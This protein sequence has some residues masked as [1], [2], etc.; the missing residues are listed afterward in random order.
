MRWLIHKKKSEMGPLLMR[1]ILWGFLFFVAVGAVAACGGG[2]SKGSSAGA[3]VGVT[4]EQAAAGAAD[5]VGGA[6]KSLLG[7]VG[8]SVGNSSAAETILN[9]LGIPPDSDPTANL[10]AQLGEAIAL[11]LENGQRT[12]DAVTFDPDE[13]QLCSDPLLGQVT[14]LVGVGQPCIDFYSHITVVLTPGGNA[15]EGTL[16]IKY[17]NFVLATID[18]SSG[19]VSLQL[20]LA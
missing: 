14:L 2:G 19:S 18:Y 17:D 11:I 1:S 20:D 3:P 15:E 12:G 9:A 4:P 10:E 6:S 16:E 8:K 7:S 5:T 13:T